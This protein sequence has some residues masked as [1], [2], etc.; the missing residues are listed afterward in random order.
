MPVVDLPLLRSELA[1]PPVCSSPWRSP[2]APLRAAKRERQL[3]RP[4]LLSLRCRP[5]IAPIRLLLLPRHYAGRA[6]E[7]P[8]VADALFLD[9]HHRY[10]RTQAPTIRDQTSSCPVVSPAPEG[11]P[12]ACAP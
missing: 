3:P 7:P 6:S 8:P 9:T 4:A 10:H 12:D 2:A 1:L 11:A 5:R